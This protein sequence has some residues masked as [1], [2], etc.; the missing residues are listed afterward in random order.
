MHQFKQARLGC[1]LV[2]HA[3]VKV[4]T[5]KFERQAQGAAVGAEE[6]PITTAPMRSPMTTNT[7]GEAAA[8]HVAELQARQAACSSVSEAIQQTLAVAQLDLDGTIVAANENFLR[9]MGYELS[10]V[11]GQHHSMFCSPAQAAGAEYRNF[12]AGLRA[13]K[14]QS[15]EFLRVTR[16]GEPIWLRATYTPIRDEDG[17]CRRVVKFAQDITAE[18]LAQLDARG[19]LQAIDR[20]QAVIEFDMQGHVLDANKNFLGLMG[21]SLD[22]IRNHHHRMFV[23]PTEAASPGYLK[24]WEGLRRGE[25]S[26]GEYKRVGRDG[27]EVWIQATYNAILDARGLP[28]KVVK[29]AVDV[30]AAKLRTAEDEAK[31][32]A[33]DLSQ[34]VIEFDMD[35]VV[36]HANRNFLAAMGYT[37]R[38]VQGQHHSM[39]CTTEYTQGVE[40]RDFW[41]RLGEGKFTTGRFHRVG[42]FGRDVWI[43]ATYNPIFDLNGNVTK[44]VK[45]AYDVTN[46]VLMG[47]RV[48]A[49][50]SR[51]Q[52]SLEALVESI[53]AVAANS[54]DA[55]E[56]A[57]MSSTAAQTGQQ[58]LGRA[59]EAINAIQLTSQKVAEIVRTIGDI[60]NQTNLLAFNAA[61]EA[62]RAGEHGVGFSVV[63]AEVRKLAERSSAAA[64]Q[65]ALMNDESAANVRQSVTVSTDAAASFE[66]ITQ[67]VH[68]TRVSVGAIADAATRQHQMAEEVTAMIRTLVG[69]P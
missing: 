3:S 59:I 42:K 64:N 68:R 39:F 38:E 30:T 10:E 36:R 69:T 62:A 47:Q 11:A 32:A 43:Q 50:S 63:A 66:G 7:P 54:S 37:L 51:M 22:D 33:I 60:A 53:T 55:S 27:R 5:G 13:C 24:F 57:T 28:C 40:Y 56:L 8:I 23:T 48:Q 67:S 17:Q 46:E 18:K 12:W 26:A 9:S 1:G 52:I 44:V 25:F 49:Q 35:G 58:A 2:V 45:Y 41:L 14:P 16:S 31:L 29:F 4:A 6:A 65:I 19:K 20:A 61:I 34:A 15:G 21:Y